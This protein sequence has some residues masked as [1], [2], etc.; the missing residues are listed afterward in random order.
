MAEKKIFSRW[1]IKED[2]LKGMDEKKARDLIVKCFFEAQRE[3]FARIKQDMGGSTRD[4]DLMVNVLASIRM[5][6]RE[7]G[8]DFDNPTREGITKAVETLAKKAGS[9]GTPQDIIDFHKGQIMK[10]LGLLR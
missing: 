8:S 6:F 2:D 1:T 9:W 5:V 10:V 3:T 4:E 7:T